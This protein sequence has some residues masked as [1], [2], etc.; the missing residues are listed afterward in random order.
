[1]DKIF[2][3]DKKE[4]K[5]EE[6][7][8][9]EGKEHEQKPHDHAKLHKVEKY[10]H[11]EEVREADDNIWGSKAHNWSTTQACQSRCY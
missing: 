1:M 9:H 6:G 8:S 10:L 2:H 11:D 7:K 3:H 4:H 5:E